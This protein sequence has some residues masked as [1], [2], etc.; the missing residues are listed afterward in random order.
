MKRQIKF[1]VALQVVCGLLVICGLLSADAAAQNR[2]GLSQRGIV[3]GEPSLPQGAALKARGIFLAEGKDRDK[4][5][6]VVAIADE[7]RSDGRLKPGE[8]ASFEIRL[9]HN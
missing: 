1:T 4:A 2:N 7:R 8:V 5:G 6:S 9:Q 3:T